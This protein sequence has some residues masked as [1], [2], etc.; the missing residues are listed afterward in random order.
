MTEL[1]LGDGSR[2][3]F[4]YKTPV[5]HYKPSEFLRKTSH[6]WSKTTSKHINQWD[7]AKWSD[8]HYSEMPQE[9][10]DNITKGL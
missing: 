6:K 8:M 10:F 4:S 1:I 9:Y 7:I 5:A 2:V 3:L